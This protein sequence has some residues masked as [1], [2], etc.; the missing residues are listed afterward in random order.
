V[1]QLTTSLA[2]VA[3]S[4]QAIAIAD[5]GWFHRLN[6]SF[7]AALNVIPVLGRWRVDHRI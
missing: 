3:L 4:F 5:H 6:D 2:S 7:F 1:F